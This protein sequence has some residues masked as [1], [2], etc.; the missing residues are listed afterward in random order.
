MVERAE[1]WWY[2][3]PSKKM[4]KDLVEGTD[5]LGTTGALNGIGEV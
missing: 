3:F 1:V 4:N 2:F 5:G